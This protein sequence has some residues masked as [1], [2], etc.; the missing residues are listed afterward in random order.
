METLYEKGIRL[1][2]EYLHRRKIV[3]SI[4]NGDKEK[5]QWCS[6]HRSTT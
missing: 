2:R 5:A 4:K 6:Q 3:S 1:R